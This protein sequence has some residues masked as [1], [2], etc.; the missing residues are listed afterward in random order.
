MQSHPHQIVSINLVA[1]IKRFLDVWFCNF[2]EHECL[3]LWETLR[4]KR[5]VALRIVWTPRYKDCKHCM[6]LFREFSI[7]VANCWC[8]AIASS[9]HWVSLVSGLSHYPFPRNI[10]HFLGSSTGKETPDS[11]NPDFKAYH[12]PVPDDNIMIF[13]HWRKFILN[14]Q[15]TFSK[16]IN[17][18]EWIT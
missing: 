18:N 11:E 7:V 9:H 1:F 4:R 13:F 2:E 10:Q 17:I 8:K 6:P 5:H 14:K 16:E 15:F 12:R 3:K